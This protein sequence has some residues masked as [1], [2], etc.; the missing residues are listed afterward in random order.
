V[1][2]LFGEFSRAQISVIYL[3]VF[4]ILMNVNY[5][6]CFSCSLLISLNLSLNFLDYPVN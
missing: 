1:F 2:D 3:F 4:V 6:I 5:F